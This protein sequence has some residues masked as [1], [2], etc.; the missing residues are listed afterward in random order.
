MPEPADDVTIRPVRVEDAEAIWRIAREEGVIENILALPS[1]RL[2]Q[3]RKQLSELGPDEHF[4]VAEVSD[5][6]VGLAG[7]QVGRG[8][9]RHSGHL[10]VY[11]SRGHQV[12]GI[13]TRLIAALLD[14]ADNWLLLRRVELT[15]LVKNER[16]RRLYERLGFEV[17]GRRKL[18]VIAKGEIED[19][20]LMARYR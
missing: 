19:E 18:S 9:L 13:G 8:R 7:L 1:D 11:V 20:W 12:H 6:V 15:V 3:R 5:A 2:E 14:L 4:V 16:A 10:F 17:E